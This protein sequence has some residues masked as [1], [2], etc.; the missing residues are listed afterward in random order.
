[1]PKRGQN[2]YKR[3]DGRWEGRYI[4]EHSNDKIKYGYIYAKTC[5]EAK[6][7]LLEVSSK[8]KGTKQPKVSNNLNFK[9]VAEKWLETLKSQLKI[10]SCVKYTYI[11]N[12]SVDPEVNDVSL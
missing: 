12:S 10:S 5:K 7:K 11:V 9:A 1:M 8:T 4:K 2:I 3:N 6:E